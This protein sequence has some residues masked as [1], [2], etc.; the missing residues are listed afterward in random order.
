MLSKYLVLAFLLHSFISLKCGQNEIVN[1]VIL[2]K[3]KINVYYV[4]INIFQF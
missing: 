2:M 3:M 1:N 4:K